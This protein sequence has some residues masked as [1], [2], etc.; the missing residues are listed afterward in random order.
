M[1]VVPCQHKGRGWYLCDRSYVLGKRRHLILE[2]YGKGRPTLY[3]P[4]VES[5]IAEEK[6][7]LLLADSFDLVYL[8]PPYGTTAGEWDIAPDWAWLGE[9][10]ARVLKPT[11]QVV[12][13][14]SGEMA[15]DAVAAFK[16]HLSHRFELVWVKERSDGRLRTTAW[17][18]DK[19]PLRAHELIHVF[20]RKNAPTGSLTLNL[21]AMHRHVD[22][23]YGSRGASPTHQGKEGWSGNFKKNTSG[24]RWPIDVMFMAPREK[25]ELYAA[26]PQDLVRLL[27]AALT[28][29]GDRILDPY[30]GTGTTLTIAFRLGRQA[31]GIEAS[32]K[33]FKVLRTEMEQWGSVGEEL[34]QFIRG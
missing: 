16:P 12:L 30:A 34:Q 24:Y 14:G 11:G 17:V 32:P 8:D 25:S 9:Q 27:V 21:G 7:P 20:K 6:L 26:K 2:S 13:N 5:G 19:E 31:H 18:S 1:N 33:A 15:A 4:T 23:S 3:P 29:P 10:T 28:K 22:G